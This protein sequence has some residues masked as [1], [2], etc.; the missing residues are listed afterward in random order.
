M[1]EVDN[2]YILTGGNM[3]RSIRYGHFQEFLFYI[4]L[5]SSISSGLQLSN[6]TQI[7]RLFLF[8]LVWYIEMKVLKTFMQVKLPYI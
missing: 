7:I 2:L 6:C 4:T 5:V 8:Q 1:F 3:L